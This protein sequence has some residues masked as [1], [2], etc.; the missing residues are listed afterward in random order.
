MALDIET[1]SNRSGGYSFFKAAG[2]PAVAAQA[3]A[4]IARI[5][6][7]GP[8]AVYDPLGFAVPF[9]ALHPLSGLDL[10]HVFVQ[11]VARIGERL[12]GRNAE[13]VTALARAKVKALLV[14]AFDAATI[15]AHVRHLVPAGCDIVTLDAM[16]LPD[17]RLTVPGTYLHNLNFATNFAFFRDTGTG[18]AA[19]HTRVVTANYWHGYKARSVRLWL[20]LLGADGARLAEWEEALP[21]SPA[22]VAIDSRAVRR[23]FGLAEFTGQLFIHAIGVAGHDIVKYALDTYG[24]DGTVLSCTHD[25]NAW[26]ADFYAG[27]PAPA[28]GERVVLWVQNSH[29]CPIPAGAIGLNP[30][31]E[32]GKAVFLDRAV[33]AFGTA[34]LDVA[35]LLPGLAWPTQIEIRAGKHFVRPRYEIEQAGPP[36][37]LRIAHPNVERTDLEPDPRIAALGATL[38]KGYILPAPVLPR[39]RWR[40]TALITPM[41]RS[42]DHLPVAVV[43]YDSAGTE[44]ARRALGEL[45]RRDSVAVDFDE[46]FPGAP[47]GFRGHMELVYDFSAGGTAAQRG[48]DGWLH[49]LFRYEDRASGHIAETSFGAHVFNTV[50]TFAGEPQSYVGRPPG[51]STRL[52]LRAAPGLGLGADPA[53]SSVGAETFCQLIYPAST[54]WHATSQTRLALHDGAGREVAARDIAIPCSGSR[55]FT[56]SEMFD[57]AERHAAIANDGAGSAY[58]LIRDTTCRLFGYHGLETRGGG[59]FSLDHMFGF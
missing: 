51:L 5:A 42:Q 53:D 8:V 57:E 38:G 7:A 22:G 47:A 33:P 27:L 36:A 24:E 35:T 15:V 29:P 40:S 26:P 9:A 44:V 18:A 2:H 13:P 59:A 17:A 55:L 1:F 30:M 11:D 12:L 39:D 43:A 28:E 34:A 20:Q 58:V 3:R 50:L 46:L 4:M 10:A 16:R 6:A 54:P 31:G 56:V 48:V 49:G 14:V 45:R 19:H 21:D 37:R 41:A 23:R 25:A 52:F 32:D